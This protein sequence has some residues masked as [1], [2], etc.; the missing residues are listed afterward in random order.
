MLSRLPPSACKG[1]KPPPSLPLWMNHWRS[2]R[3]TITYAA[4]RAR[5]RVT[6]LLLSEIRDPHKLCLRNGDGSLL[7]RDSKQLI[8]GFSAIVLF[9]VVLVLLQHCNLERLG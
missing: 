1:V 4:A 9:G 5:P 8:I 7:D 2:D 6:V 3:S